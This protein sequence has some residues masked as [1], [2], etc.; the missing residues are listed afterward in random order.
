LR[1]PGQPL[2]AD[3]RTFMEPRFG[4]DFSAVRVHNDIM[5]AES[6][7][8]VES[9]AYTVGSDVV[10]GTGQYT[11]GTPHGDYLLAHEL[12][13]VI[14]QEN[15][16]TS[17]GINMPTA[18]ESG[19][20]VANKAAA[21]VATATKTDPAFPAIGRSQLTLAKGEKW[22]DFWG[23]GPWDSYKAKQLAEAALSK[24][25]KTG[26]PGLHNGA[27]DAWRHCYW[28][29]TM[30]A[31][32]GADQAEEV[33]SNHEKYGG[34]PANENSMD[35]QNNAKGRACGGKN[36]DGCCQTKLDAGE[37]RVID[38]KSGAVV[39]S[40]PTARSTTPAAGSGA[41]KY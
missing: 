31:E 27:A 39:P 21:Y 10:F 15:A 14:Q 38:S 37:L 17:R 24:A 28:N 1:S 18:G 11:P 9:L 19:E 4:H 6:A 3:T 33:A 13:H 2:D 7:R 30:T 34:G 22:A 8:A 29:C 12:T 23:V 40:G 41:Y 25:Q 20:I 35:I 16:A 36:C 32:I 5:A 26:L